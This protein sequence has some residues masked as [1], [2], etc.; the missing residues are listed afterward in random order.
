M[1]DTKVENKKEYTLEE[2]LDCAAYSTVAIMSLLF[3]LMI[4][5][6]W[7]ESIL[8]K[9]VSIVLIDAMVVVASTEYRKL[10]QMY[11][12]VAIIAAMITVLLLILLPNPVIIPVYCLMNIVG[13]R[14][15]YEWFKMNLS[16]V[17]PG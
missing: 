11:T 5:L 4:F 6:V 7:E 8:L 13:D 9:V 12:V 14:I 10:L 15:I 2:Q 1:V 16:L 17:S 3:N